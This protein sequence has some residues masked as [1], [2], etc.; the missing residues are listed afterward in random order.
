M[1]ESDKHL[2]GD[3]CDFSHNEDILAIDS[4][5]D[6]VGGPYF[7]VHKNS[8]ERYALVALEWCGEPAIGIR[9]FWDTVG[10]P[11]S[12]SFPTWTIIPTAF[13]RTLQEHFPLNIKHK[14]PVEDFLTG[15]ITGEEL[16]ARCK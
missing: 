9:W 4:P 13:Y 7:V 16:A 12:S 6:M 11:Q 1:R 5:K 8:E 2:G 3:A 14:N 10:N 15:K